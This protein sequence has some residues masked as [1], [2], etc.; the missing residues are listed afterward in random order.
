MSKTN[1]S[2]N[3]N[4]A[5]V[6]LAVAFVYSPIQ[7]SSIPSISN[8]IFI[9]EVTKCG[10]LKSGVWHV[11]GTTDYIDIQMITVR[12]HSSINMQQVNPYPS[13]V[14]ITGSIDVEV[15]QDKTTPPYW[16]IPFRH[17]SDVIV[18]PKLRVM[19]WTKA[20]QTVSPKTVSI[21]QSVLAARIPC[22]IHNKYE[23]H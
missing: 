3:N 14:Q 22:T 12:M 10:E 11:E 21:W 17:E 4:F 19:E 13:D 2:F 5:V 23:K 1:I 18:H 20:G 15:T 16:K 8:F 6:I 9:Q 7:L